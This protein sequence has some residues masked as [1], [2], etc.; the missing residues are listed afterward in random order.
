MRIKSSKTTIEYAGRIL[1][2]PGG[3]FDGDAISDTLSTS[4]QA[5][6]LVKAPFKRMEQ[7]A[8]ASVDRSFSFVSDFDSVEAAIQYKLEAEEHGAA[9]MNGELTMSIGENMLRTYEAALNS[10]DASISLSPSSVRVVLRYDFT[11]G[12]RIDDDK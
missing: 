5:V 11:T 12:E 10:L 1:V 2:Q 6:A 9:N 8:N 3:Y 4:A 7:S